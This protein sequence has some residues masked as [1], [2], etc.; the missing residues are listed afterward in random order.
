MISHDPEDCVFLS[1][2]VLVLGQKPTT[3]LATIPIVFENPRDFN[4]TSDRR[5]MQLQ[6]EVVKSACG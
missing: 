5:F 3:L 6:H 2:K 1:D 4:L